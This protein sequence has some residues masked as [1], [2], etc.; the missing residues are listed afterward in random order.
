MYDFCLQE[1]TNLLNWRF[2]HSYHLFVA[3]SIQM[4]EFLSKRQL[5]QSLLFICII[6]R[7]LRGRLIYITRGNIIGFRQKSVKPACF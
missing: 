3:V 1:L 2:C 7:N 4:N 5:W 6:Y